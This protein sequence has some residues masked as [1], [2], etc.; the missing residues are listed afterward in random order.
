MSTPVMVMYCSDF[1]GGGYL[2]ETNKCP[3][4]VKIWRLVCVQSLPKQ[5]YRQTPH[6]DLCAI[7]YSLGD[8]PTALKHWDGACLHIWHLMW[9]LYI[10]SPNIWCELLTDKM[11]LLIKCFSAI[12][13]LT[14]WTTWEN[15]DFAWENLFKFIIS[16]LNW[17]YNRHDVTA[18][19]WDQKFL[20]KS[21][22]YC[23]DRLH[24]DIKMTVSSVASTWCVR[25]WHTIY[26]PQ[27]MT[28]ILKSAYN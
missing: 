27:T 21:D 15:S 19:I 2:G 22:L 9:N 24:L 26:R 17:S 16:K 14:I 25:F 13:F 1:M 10:V 6:I 5:C 20:L 18:A 3:D 4:L 28:Q 12:W 23:P 8:A 11:N 7:E